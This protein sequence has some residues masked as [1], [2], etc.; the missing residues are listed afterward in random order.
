MLHSWFLFYLIY[1]CV[2]IIYYLL[3]KKITGVNLILSIIG[4]VCTPKESLLQ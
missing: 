2:T 1:N 4:F 3:M